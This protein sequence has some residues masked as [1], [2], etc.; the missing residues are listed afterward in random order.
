MAKMTAE[1][2]TGGKE[3]KEIRSKAKRYTSAELMTI[4]SKL[5]PGETIRADGTLMWRPTKAQYNGPEKPKSVYAN[6]LPELREK[7][8]QAL[9]SLHTAISNR[10]SRI[11]VNGMYQKWIKVKAGIRDNTK[12]NYVYMYEHFI[13]PSVLGRTVV[14]NVGKSDI[15]A[16]YNKLVDEGVMG[17]STLDCLQNL[18][19]QI[20]GLA[21][22]DRII[23][24]NPAL[25]ALKQFKRATNNGNQ[26]G[27]PRKALTV[28]EQF[29]F[30][31]YLNN[32]EENEAWRNLFTVLLGTGLRISELCGLTWNNIDFDGEMITIDHDLIY[33]D[34]RTET[35]RCSLEIHEPKTEAGNRVLPMLPFVKE[36]LLREKD[37]QKR[38]G[39]KCK[40]E[41]GGYKNFVFVNRFQEV[42]RHATCNRVLKRIIR[43]CNETILLKA[44]KNRDPVL[45]PYFTCHSLRH[46]CVTRLIENGV[47]V[48]AVQ[49]YVGH[50]DA[51]TTLNIYT[52]CQKEFLK[53]SFGLK[54][55]KNYRDIFTENLIG[56]NQN[57]DGKAPT[58]LVESC[59]IDEDMN[60][61]RDFRR[62]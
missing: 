12:S 23:P 33:Y 47:N 22:D 50:V 59:Y 9:K 13:E 61:F 4:R 42:Q 48:V 14:A 58:N 15:L 18:L 17:V 3:S 20:F 5:Q 31:D 10:N 57:H 38:L 25:G 53:E 1:N 36:A 30:L 56:K 21:V 35:D 37:R 44:P 11:T 6:S 34:K 45:L 32:I 8:E 54:V 55:E 43:D 49:H 28:P 7:E 26:K 41:V 40:T 19:T 62:R 29:V 16:F 2:G 24:S 27:M 51:A 60:A 46:T 39:L 52:D